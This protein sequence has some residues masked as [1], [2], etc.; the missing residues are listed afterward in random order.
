M[1]LVFPKYN[2]ID[3][4]EAAG[5]VTTPDRLKIR[6]ARW[7]ATAAP[8]KG[9]I[10][11]LQGR[12]EYI[13]KYYETIDQLRADGFEVLAFDWRGQGGSDR[14]LDDPRRGYVDTFDDYAL[15]FESVIEDIL[16]PDCRAPYYVLAHST[17]GLVALIAATRV[18]NKIRRM[19]LCSP[20]LGINGKGISSSWIY[21]ATGTMTALGLGESFVGRGGTPTENIP[22]ANNLVTS[23]SERFL[24]NRRF[25]EDHRELSIG[26]P[27]ANW[28]F[29]AGK[30]IE[31]VFDP[32]FYGQ[33]SIPAL[34]VLSGADQVVDSNASEQLARR[35]RTASS[36]IIDGAKHELLQEQDRFREQAFAAFNAFVPGSDPGQNF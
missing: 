4:P 20:F 28:I 8:I 24:R 34:F 13:E 11:L 25:V 1:V 31:R 9:T 33:I 35:M 18:R 6:Y 32:D 2:S 14:L 19:V 15:D 22:Y 16:L 12:A 36:L 17:G 10:V 23:D 5:Y 3:E 27:T 30:A 7:K 26:G 29:A 21:L